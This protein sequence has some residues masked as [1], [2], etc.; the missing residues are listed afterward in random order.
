MD[1]L[2]TGDLEIRVER[3]SDPVTDQVTVRW[4]GVSDARDPGVAISPYLDRLVEELQGAVVCIDFSAMEYMNS[5]TVA[6]ILRFIRAL[7]REAARIIILYDQ[8]KTFQRTTFSAVR[9]L[10]ILLQKLEVKAV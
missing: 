9:A 10:G 4:R 8:G 2:C 6:P 1:E 7:D 5:A 3:Q